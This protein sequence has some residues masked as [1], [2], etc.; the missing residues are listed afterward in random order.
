M[1]PWPP[2]TMA[3]RMAQEGVTILLEHSLSER[4]IIRAPDIEPNTVI[5]E[6]N[7]VAVGCL[8][9]E[10]EVRHVQVVDFGDMRTHGLASE[11]V[12][13]HADIILARRLLPIDA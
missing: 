8:D 6:T 7:H 3:L 12:D 13:S 1:K 5:A 9:L 11:N 4:K 2:V 10:Q